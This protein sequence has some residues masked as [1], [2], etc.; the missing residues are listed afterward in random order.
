MSGS[1]FAALLAASLS[2]APA[3]RAQPQESSCA[4]CHRL[5]AGALS[6]PVEDYAGDVHAAKG[7]GCVACHGG[8]ESAPAP[9]A[10]MDPAK[11]FIGKPRGEPLLQVCG[12]CHSDPEFMKRYNPALRVDQVAEYRS[13]IHGQRLLE[14]GDPKVATC[15]SCHPTHS[16]K[17]PSDPNSTVHPLRV[18]GTCGACH[19]DPD[20]M[21]GYEIPSDQLRKYTESVHWQA[22]S[23]RGDLS[24]P[25]CNDC[26]GNHG[27]TPPGVDWVGN[28]CGQ[29][30]SVMADL[31]G[32][33]RHARIFTLL[34]TPGCATCHRNHEVQPAGDEML[35][36][37]D[38]AVCGRCHSPESRS[39]MAAAQMRGLID[40]L[41]LE[42][43]RARSVL[44]RAERAGME[45]S[46]AL[47]ELNDA[48]NALVS[49]RAAVHAF[50]LDSVRGPVEAG[51]D[52]TEVA[53]IRGQRAL[54]ELRFRRMGLAVS[55]VIILGL[56]GGL[57]LKI[58]QIEG[59]A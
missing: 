19:G 55:V 49:A 23:V 14:L 30:H 9:A 41:N 51:L 42:L 47:F 12:R 52:V 48:Q 11:G 40:S 44:H 33:S 1:A 45:V 17:P 22:L 28:V 15:V 18:P 10:A 43:Q 56:I 32:R 46:Q 13:S 54:D 59:R 35:G 8:D 34:G 5:L 57:V 6:K 38:G 29:C 31:F 16:M 2:W 27:A 53:H 20:Y 25:A 37:G 50:H 58:R 36:L 24:A 26:H 4:R 3:P 21:Q 7:F 39:G